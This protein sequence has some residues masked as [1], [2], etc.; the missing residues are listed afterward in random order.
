MADIYGI[1]LFGLAVVAVLGAVAAKVNIAPRSLDRVAVLSRVLASITAA[2]LVGLA[3]VA[4]RLP[5]PAAGPVEFF[6][7]RT[8]RDSLGMVLWLLA[9]G[10]SGL[11]AALTLVIVTPSRTT[12]RTGRDRF[13]AGLRRWMGGCLA[14][15]TV[16]AVL[17]F[18]AVVVLF[19]TAGDLL[20]AQ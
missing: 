20:P 4:D 9:A 15:A 3:F 19:L 11:L 5:S 1:F 17:L 8:G 14:V 16:A 10:L 6:L 2:G 12:S 18:P 7:D 13:V